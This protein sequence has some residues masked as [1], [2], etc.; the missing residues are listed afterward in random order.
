MSLRDSRA[1]ILRR[2]LRLLD[3][4]PVVIATSMDDRGKACWEPKRIYINP[5]HHETLQ[6]LSHTLVHELIHL[7][8]PEAGESTCDIVAERLMTGSRTLQAR[9]YSVLAQALLLHLLKNKEEPRNSRSR[10]RRI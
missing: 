1:I 5:L 10:S 4:V 2:V 9:V 3:V 6:D 8:L 7:V